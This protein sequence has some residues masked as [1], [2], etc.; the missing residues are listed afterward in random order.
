MSN[1]KQ[2]QKSSGTKG[3]GAMPERGDTSHVINADTR[4]IE[5]SSKKKPLQF[6][7]DEATFNDFS[8][9]AAAMFGHKKGTK[10]QYFEYLNNKS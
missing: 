8:T 7:V 9:K 10:T 2:L 1:V 4:P 3:K 5:T 6:M